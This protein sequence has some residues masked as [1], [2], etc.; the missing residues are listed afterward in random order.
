MFDPS[1]G[2]LDTE[3]EDKSL[4]QEPEERGEQAVTGEQEGDGGGGGRIEDEDLVKDGTDARVGEECK[5]G[6]ERGLAEKDK[7]GDG[8]GGTEGA[9]EMTGDREALW[10]VD[11]KADDKGEALAMREGVAA[12]EKAQEGVGTEEE[13]V[14]REEEESDRGSK[15]GLHEAVEGDKWEALQED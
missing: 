4:S 15:R 3:K 12:E 6:A 7:L 9:D 10:G 1:A 11:G 13:L 2:R 5:A 14:E 8:G